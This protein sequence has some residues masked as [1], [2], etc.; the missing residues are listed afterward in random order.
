MRTNL[1]RTKSLFNGLTAY[2]VSDFANDSDNVWSDVAVVDAHAHVSWTYDYYFKRF[3]RNGL[4][5]RNGPIDIVVNAVSQQGA[6]SL[7]NADF[8]T[9]AVNAFWCGSCGPGGR[10]VIFFG[11]GIPPGVF[12][13]SNGRNYT[14]FS[15]A[16]DIAAHELTHAVSRA[17]R[18]NTPRACTR[19]DTS[20]R[21]KPASSEATDLV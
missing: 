15:G 5:G 13:S 11:S 21:F 7:S 3:G 18:G 12:L 2:T 4:D 1:D 16:L 19:N 8:G 10:G 6:L 9:Y 20:S 17:L 14:Y